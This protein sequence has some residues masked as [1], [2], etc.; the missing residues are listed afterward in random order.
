MQQYS[1]T[2]PDRQNGMEGLCPIVPEVYGI[3]SYIFVDGWF[4][5]AGIVGCAGNIAPCA[6]SIL[7]MVT[8]LN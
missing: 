5:V 8:P 6:Y 3:L 2:L 4:A 1:T 7:V